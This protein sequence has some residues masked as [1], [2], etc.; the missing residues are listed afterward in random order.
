MK[1]LALD[2]S[3]NII[4]YAV[5]DVETGAL[6]DG[7]LIKPAKTTAEPLHRV[8]TMLQDLGDLIDEHDPDHIAIEMPLSADDGKSLGR[9][10]G[11]IIWAAAAWSVWAYLLTSSRSQLIP[12]S[13]R[14]WTKGTKKQGR[15]RTVAAM[16]PKRYDPGQDKGADLADA[17]SLG[18]WALARI[19]DTERARCLRQLGRQK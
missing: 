17:I 6:I 3:S 9:K 19:G 8:T 7:G 11:M 5:L 2:P 10:P 12:V 16:Y 18:Q 13:N 15:Q 14:D 4:G 1:L